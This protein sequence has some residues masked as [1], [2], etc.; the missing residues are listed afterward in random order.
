M[1]SDGR[2]VRDRAAWTWMERLLT[3]WMRSLEL[4]C[5]RGGT[6]SATESFRRGLDDVVRLKTPATVR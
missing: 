4:I 2:D 5:R 6:E 1:M 3:E